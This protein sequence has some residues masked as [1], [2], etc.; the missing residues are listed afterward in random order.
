[1]LS[2]SAT[3]F[4]GHESKKN[5]SLNEI[6]IEA[7]NKDD[8]E[9]LSLIAKTTRHETYPGYTPEK[10]ELMYGDYFRNQILNHELNNSDCIIL[11]IKDE[12]KIFGYAK[13]LFDKDIPV[14][15]KLYLL[16]SHQGQGHGSALLFRCFEITCERGFNQMWLEAYRKNIKALEFYEKHGFQRLDTPVSFVNAATEEIHTN[17]DIAMKCDD[18]AKQ[19]RSRVGR[20]LI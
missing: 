16:K 19:L 10:L 5:H 8:I 20:K 15:D 7:F 3:F 1:M 12:S 14:L 11:V 2:N 4:T 6:T 13:L 9:Q 17:S 18:I